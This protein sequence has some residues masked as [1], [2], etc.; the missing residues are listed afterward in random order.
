MRREEKRNNE[1][2]KP[3]NIRR[4]LCLLYILAFSSPHFFFSILF[5]FRF[6]YIY[7]QHINTQT[8]SAHN[9]HTHLLLLLAVI[10]NAP[11]NNN[12]TPTRVGKREISIERNTYTYTHTTHTHN[13]TEVKIYKAINTCSE[14]NKRNDTILI[15]R[16]LGHSIL[17][18]CSLYYNCNMSP[19]FLFPLDI[20]RYTKSHFTFNIQ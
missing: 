18:M 15:V 8:H 19:R 10:T 6:L 20:F 14:S 17:K 1:T 7:F 3:I 16:L 13:R 11:A 12:I 9:T 2:R 5:S 4:L